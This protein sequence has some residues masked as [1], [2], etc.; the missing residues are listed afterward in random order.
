MIFM[1]LVA[2]VR[3][4]H[5][6]ARTLGMP[7]I[8]GEVFS[9]SFA[10]TDRENYRTEKTLA[11]ANGWIA[12]VQ[13]DFDGDRLPEICAVSIRG[14]TGENSLTF[15]MLEQSRGEWNIAAAFSD[16]DLNESLSGTEEPSRW[17]IFVHESDRVYIY[18][19][20]YGD[21][22]HF[23]DGTTWWLERL[24]Y[25]EGSFDTVL[26]GSDHDLDLGFAG[27]DI[28]AW[29]DLDPSE[30]YSDLDASE[31]SRYISAFQQAGLH[32][33]N[34]LR[35]DLPIMNDEA[36]AVPLARIIRYE[37]SETWE[38]YMIT[39]LFVETTMMDLTVPGVDL[40][41]TNPFEEDGGGFD[42]SPASGAADGYIIPD[43][44]TRLLTEADLAGLTTEELRIA[45]NEIYA[46]HGRIFRD[47]QL[48][49]YFESQS[50]YHGTIP[51]DEFSGSLLSSIEMAN[52]VF[53]REEEE[54]RAAQQ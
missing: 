49:A 16:P 25:D 23:A 32:V 50:W 12:A 52:A 28:I 39:G 17:D 8:G 7:Y 2:I 54:R 9:E 11:G 37:T 53:I 4:F 33:P 35:F 40:S 1:L 15:Y 51:A 22:Y 42:L 27:S 46:R 29:L 36:S 44:S 26:F 48:Q 21:E 3:V 20:H 14:V 6:L 31:I 18:I 24:A 45:R 38:D 34:S 5:I 10:L 47:Q 43:S 41:V 19:E 30:A 13:R